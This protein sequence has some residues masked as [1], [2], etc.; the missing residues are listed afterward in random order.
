MHHQVGDLG[1][2]RV[3]VWRW[4]VSGTSLKGQGANVV[5][6]DICEVGTFDGFVKFSD[7]RR[8]GKGRSLRLGTQILPIARNG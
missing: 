4:A 3:E 7:V 1:N 8:Y 2:V 5:S 6:T